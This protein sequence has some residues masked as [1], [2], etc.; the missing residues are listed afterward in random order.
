MTRLPTSIQT[1]LIPRESEVHTYGPRAPSMAQP[2]WEERCRQSALSRRS[3][4][5]GWT[6]RRHCRG[7]CPSVLS[8]TEAGRGHPTHLAPA[9][10]T[11]YHRSAAG[12]APV[13]S[14]P[15]APSCVLQSVP[16]RA[17]RGSAAPPVFQLAPISSGEAIKRPWHG[18]P[19]DVESCSIS[20]D[21]EDS[22]APSPEGGQG[23]NHSFC[24]AAGN[25]IVWESMAYTA[26]PAGS[27][28]QSD[29]AMRFS[30]PGDLPS[31]AALSRLRWQSE[32]HLSCARRLLSSWQRMQSSRSL[33]PR[34][35]RGEPLLH[36]T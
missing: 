26:R 34:W 15:W 33:Q 19:G 27:F 8:S 11:I 35:G 5:P 4:L 1:F 24:S 21:G 20:G 6:V 3:R 31:S 25:H 30:S 28:A 10:C 32:T 22:A 16:C 14:S 13:C 36:R 2:C 7:L 9:W 18:Q 23:E 12:Q 17:T 29:S